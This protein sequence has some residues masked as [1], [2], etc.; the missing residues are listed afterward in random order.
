MTEEAPEVRGPPPATVARRAKSYSDFYDVVTEHL[1]KTEGSHG[2]KARKAKELKTE[3]DFGVW[4][5]EIEDELL[6]ASNEEHMYAR[7]YFLPY[8]AILTLISSQTVS[9]SATADTVAPSLHSRH[10]RFVA[11]TTLLPLRLFQSC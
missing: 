11:H 7:R 2:S 8:S 9:R 10:H 5:E 3:L 6:D 4:Y 1:K